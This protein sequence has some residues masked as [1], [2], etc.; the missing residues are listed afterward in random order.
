MKVIRITDVEK[1]FDALIELIDP[2]VTYEEAATLLNTT[3]HGVYCRVSRQKV[4]VVHHAKLIHYSDVLK[5]RDVS[6][7]KRHYKRH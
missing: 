2:L 3:R 5:M 7:H 4:N 1:L 6:E